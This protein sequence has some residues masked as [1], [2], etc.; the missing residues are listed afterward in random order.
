MKREI[1]FMPAYDK[2]NDPGGNF[3]I[4]G[5]V[6][7]FIVYGDEGVLVLE[8]STN[9]QLKHLR[10]KWDSYETAIRL[11]PRAVALHLHTFFPIY[12]G[13]DGPS[14]ESCEFLD[15][16]KCYC[17]STYSVKELLDVLIEGGDKALWK[18]LE[19]RYEELMDRG[20]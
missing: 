2:R 9:W 10:P 20:D 3:G 11:L 6:I 5:V 18:E 4:H 8:L 7:Y 15:G 16:H 17:I 12:D 1:R 14:T 13:Q 19:R